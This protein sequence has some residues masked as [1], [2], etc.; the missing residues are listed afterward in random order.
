M[1][2]TIVISDSDSEFER[3]VQEVTRRSLMT[4]ARSPVRY[5]VQIV[6][7]SFPAP[8]WLSVES[9]GACN[10]WKQYHSL[11]LGRR[12]VSFVSRQLP[13]ACSTSG[14][15]LQVTRSW[16]RALEQGY[17]CAASDTSFALLAEAWYYFCVAVS[18]LRQHCHRLVV[19]YFRCTS[20]SVRVLTRA[21]QI[22]EVQ[23]S[24]S[25]VV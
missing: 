19:N 7:E 4:V 1:M 2:A 6:K 25:T 23:I 13:V 11:D 16:A 10:S 3:D 8:S 18:S 22:T 21:V 12:Y 24:T 9:L 5:A 15:V 14:T 17:R 20:G